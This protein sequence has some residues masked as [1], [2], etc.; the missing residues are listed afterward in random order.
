MRVVLVFPPSLCLPNQIYYA[1]PLLASV[2][3]SAGHCVRGIDLNLA[4]AHCFLSEGCA[5]LYLRM[6]RETVNSHRAYGRVQ[7]AAIVRAMLSDLEPKVLEGPAAKSV[8]QDPDRFYDQPAFKRAFWT[9]VDALSFFY[10]LDPIISPHRDSF[11]RDMVETLDRRSWTPLRDIETELVDEVLEDDPDLVGITLAFPEQNV[12]ALRLAQAVRRRRP[13]VH[14]SLGG[15]LL[16]IDPH[17]WIEGGWLFRYVDSVVIGDGDVAFPELLD[18]LD[19]GR[20]LD[21]V[22][23]L[24]W[25]DSTGRV[26]R[27]HDPPVLADMDCLPPPDFDS[28]DLSKGLTPTPIF[29]L[30]L[31]RGCYWGKCTF[32]SIGWREN[33]RMAS[34][35][36]IRRDVADLA[37]RG[38]RYVQLQDSSVPPRGARLLAEIIREQGL[39]MFWVGGFK[40]TSQLLDREYCRALGEGGCRSLLMGF[41]SANQDLLDAMD[42]G[43][44]LRHVP[45][46]LRNLRDFGVSAELLWFVGFPGETRSDVLETVRFLYEH[47]ESF[48]LTAFVGDYQL[49][50]DTIVYDDPARFGLTVVG[51]DNGYCHY[52]SARGLQQQDLRL[53]RQV[54]SCH[55]NRTLVCN[56][57]HLPHLAEHPLDLKGLERPATIP[58]EVVKFAAVD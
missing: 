40:F 37:R 55:N 17:K 20:G 14:I 28:I 41:E 46:M 21:R 36:K 12:E 31:S 1:L 19:R 7:E 48:G 54:L 2:I 53:L 27:N 8:L 16:N 5:D 49:H 56:G 58:E 45:A 24:V 15:P 26:R 9:V 38:V 57:S 4:A 10:Q 47:R 32:C 51:Q 34:E 23:N 35:E 13:E 43:F 42:K 22:H 52:V 3:K 33:Y 39:Q 44:E 50:P 6:A 18:A 30:M 29:P 11:A 25:R